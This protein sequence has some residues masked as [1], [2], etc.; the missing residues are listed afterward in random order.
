VFSL[1]MFKP[2]SSLK[3]LFMRTNP[4]PPAIFEIK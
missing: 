2:D 1:K 3:G 4:A